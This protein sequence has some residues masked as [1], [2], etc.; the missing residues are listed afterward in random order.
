MVAHRHNELIIPHFENGVYS[1]FVNAFLR[2]LSLS[3][4]TIF[5]PFYVYKIGLQLS[6]GKP[7]AIALAL[8]YYVIAR[9]T[10]LLFSLPIAHIIESIGFRR[11]VTVGTLFLL[12]FIL[13][14]SVAY[15]NPSMLIIS[16]I[17]LGLSI[18]FY[19]IARY[20]TISEDDKT[21]R[22]GEDIGKLAILQ[23]IGAIGGPITGGLIITFFGFGAIYLFSF[24]I[25]LFSVIPIFFLPHHKHK[26]GVSLKHFLVWLEDKSYRHQAL[27][28]ISEATENYTYDLLW[29]FI[30]ILMGIKLETTGLIF[31]LAALFSII[32]RYLTGMYFDKHKHHSTFLHVATIAHSFA[33]LGRLFLID[34]ITIGAYESFATPIKSVYRNIH[35]SYSLLASKRMS[36]IAYFTYHELVY[37]ISIIIFLSILIVA[38]YTSLFKETVLIYTAVATFISVVRAREDKFQN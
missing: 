36:A 21:G 10:T 22:I 6:L 34:P 33:F 1:F 23:R 28:F 2:S 27:S 19:W 20:S 29:P 3:L 24:V 18:P 38:A 17:S 37:S 12:I 7:Q 26:N 35:D 5:I 14:L 32:A 11:S 16:S 31:S 25:L 8:L 9:S 4:I 15:K 13:A 30:I